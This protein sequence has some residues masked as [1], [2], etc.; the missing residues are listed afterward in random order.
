MLQSGNALLLENKLL[1]TESAT[2]VALR[3]L[4]AFLKE[5]KRQ[6]SAVSTVV[7]APG[8]VSSGRTVANS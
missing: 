3:C 8:H 6:V 5:T 4:R 2:Q 1:Q 7:S